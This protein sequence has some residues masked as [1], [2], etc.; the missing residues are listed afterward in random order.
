M[1]LVNTLLFS[2]L[3]FNT[4]CFASCGSYLV[5]AQ[6]V[7]KNGLSSLVINPGTK[8]EINLKVEFNESAKL[9]PYINRMIET[10]V[11]IEEKMD[12]TRGTVASLGPITVIAPDPLA[13]SKGTKFQLIQAEDCKK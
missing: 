3:V 2:Y 11:K 7:M 5:N 8:S 6:V 13:P 9:T 10:K 12:Y 1:K 4:S